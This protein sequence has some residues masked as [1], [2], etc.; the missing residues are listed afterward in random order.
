M[1]KHN[2]TKKKIINKEIFAWCMFDFANSSY[3]TVIITVLFGPIF[4][5]LIVPNSN[6]SND[7]ALG[8][9]LWAIGLAI[10][11]L[12]VVLLGPV[13]GTMSDKSPIKKKLLFYSYISCV[14]L[15]S[16]LWFVSIPKF[17]IFAFILLIFSNFAFALGENI[18]SSF[19]PFLGTKE[20]L[21]KISGYA[22]AI[23]YFGGITSVLIVRAIVG[24]TNINNIENLRL[25]GPLTGLFFL[26]AGIPTFLYLK[27]PVII[28]E[29]IKLKELLKSTYKEFLQTFSIL[30]DYKDLSIFFISLFFAISGLSIVI[31]F[32]FIYGNQEIGLSIF[33]EAITFLL[34]NLTASLGAFIFGIIQDKKGP[35]Y[36]FISTLFLWVITILALYFVKNIN[37]NFNLFFNTNFTVQS[38]FICIGGIAGLGLGAT[39]SAGR[40][41]VGIFAPEKRAGEFYG[42]WGVSG[43]LAS[44]FGLLVLAYLQIIFGLHNAILVMVLFF[45]LSIFFCFMVN[46][47][48]AITLAKK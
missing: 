45:V 20:T 15:T 14:I 33:E 28:Y 8:N 2:N 1:S 9:K 18:C 19:L 43:K 6:L 5:K 34:T 46:E 39:Q 13:F 29:K 36:T 40:A 4:T 31:S 44:A 16:L 48:R 10:S 42:F 47:K 21:G 32:T 38:F 41:I 22:W 37:Y 26:I 3:T 23:G 35:I 12:L 24:E 30:K 11:Y 25:V 17:Y 7:Y 27:E